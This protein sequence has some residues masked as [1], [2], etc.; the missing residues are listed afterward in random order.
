MKILEGEEKA[1]DRRL[2]ISINIDSEY[3]YFF[4]QPEQS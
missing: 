3:L 2:F 4:L 1:R